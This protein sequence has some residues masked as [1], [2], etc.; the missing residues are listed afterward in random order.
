M[1]KIKLISFTGIFSFFL[2]FSMNLHAHTIVCTDE[3]QENCVQ[4]ILLSKDD[5]ASWHSVSPADM[6]VLENNFY[7]EDEDIK[8]RDAIDK[9]FDFVNKQIPVEGIEWEETRHDGSTALRKAEIIRGHVYLDGKAVAFFDS[10]I[11]KIAVKLPGLTHIVVLK[12][13]RTEAQDKI[14]HMAAAIAGIDKLQLDISS[15]EVISNN[16]LEIKSNFEME[17]IEIFDESGK[18]ILK[19]KDI[20]SPELDLIIDDRFHKGNYIIKAKER[21]TENYRLRE[22]IVN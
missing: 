21:G 9:D 15:D 16:A 20:N 12:N 7:N 18:S 2:T 17:S 14:G 5:G 3:Y 1:Q 13:D 22:F 8:R 6:Q 11:R 4:F 19:K 10:K